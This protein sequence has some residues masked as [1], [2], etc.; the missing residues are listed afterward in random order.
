MAIKQRLEKFGKWMI[1]ERPANKNTRAELLEMLIQSGEKLADR[2]SMSRNTLINRIQL[3]HIIGIERWGQRRL[4]V[5]LGESFVAEDHDRHV[6]DRDRPMAEL[7]AMFRNT[8]RETISL[9]R[10]LLEA[11]PSPE[12]SVLHNQY[13]ELSL[14]EWLYYL[15]MHADMEGKRID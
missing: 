11:D 6:P 1:I 9:A 8:R 2:I 10:K 5:F 7:R 13:G 4:R 14:K 12:A 3:A 15:H